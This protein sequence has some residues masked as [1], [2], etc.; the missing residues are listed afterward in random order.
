MDVSWAF[1]FSRQVVGPMVAG[2]ACYVAGKA[3]GFAKKKKH[4]TASIQESRVSDFRIHELLSEIRFIF[5]AQRAYLV[6]FHNG[7]HYVDGSEILK[8]SRTHE[9]VSPGVSYQQTDFQGILTSR[10]PQQIELAVR[11]GPGYVQTD[12]LPDGSRF[13]GMKL[14]GGVKA[15]ASCAV[16]RRGNLIGF[17]GLDFDNEERPENIEDLCDYAGKIENL[18]A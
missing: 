10:C 13:K 15:C 9:V 6:K 3:A 4:F 1:E 16:V 5:R 18:L 11:E 12:D 8:M 2:V 7:E 14:A 17:I